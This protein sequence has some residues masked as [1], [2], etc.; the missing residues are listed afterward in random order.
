MTLP[1]DKLVIDMCEA[2]M[3][4]AV[5]P[6]AK[7]ESVI[8]DRRDPFCVNRDL[9]YVK[10]HLLPLAYLRS[11]RRLFSKAARSIDPCVP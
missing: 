4:A 2:G 10:R 6:C 9:L 8:D 11:R 5:L 7:Y 3:L 1:G